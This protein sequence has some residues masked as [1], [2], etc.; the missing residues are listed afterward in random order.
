M[1]ASS[2]LTGVAQNKL[3]R[4]HLQAMPEAVFLVDV[5]SPAILATNAQAAL[6]TGP[7]VPGF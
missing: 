7:L 6:M 4:K 2:P 3:A 1:S 5:E